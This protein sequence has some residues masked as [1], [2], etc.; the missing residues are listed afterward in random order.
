MD[1]PMASYL[2]QEHIRIARERLPCS[3]LLA[4]RK[5]S[6]AWRTQYETVRPSGKAEYGLGRC[7]EVKHLVRDEFNRQRE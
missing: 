5:A 1:G 2:L 7:S 3:A 6:A 4:A